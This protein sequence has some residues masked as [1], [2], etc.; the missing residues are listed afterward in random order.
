MRHTV[1]DNPFNRGAGL[2][3]KLVDHFLRIAELGSINRAALELGLSQ[4]T[5]AR[6][7]DQ[8]ERDLG[9]RLVVRRRTGISVTD[10]GQV[11]IARGEQLLRQAASIREELENEPAGRAVVGLPLSLRNLVTYPAIEA[12]R[13]SAPKTLMRVHEGLNNHLRD[14]L[15]QGLADL[16]VLAAGQVSE[17][18]FEQKA[19]VSEPLVLVRSR[20]LPQPKAPAS[21]E[22]IL[23]YPLTLPG[24][25]NTIRSLVERS[26]GI[27]RLA[28]AI[29]I[30]A[31]TKDL[32]IEFVRRGVVEQAVALGSGLLESDRRDFH[33]V[34]A[35]GLSVT[36][37][38]AVN[39]QRRHLPSVRHLKSILERTMQRAAGSRAWPHSRLIA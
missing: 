33:I 25:P 19:W 3:L 12:M 35:K 15:A 23:R 28:A 8:L 21:S 38:I 11:L 13:Q 24:R 27:K 1:E 32:A 20:R 5:V 39:R 36:W 31:E 34:D 2:D 29:A 7:L 22:D 9:Q 14:L 10:A 30:E 17:T 16:A 6:S 4:P 37:A 26:V 18:D